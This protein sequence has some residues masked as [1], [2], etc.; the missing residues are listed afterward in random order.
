M[1]KLPARFAWLAWVAT[2]VVAPASATTAA[3]ALAATATAAAWAV[4]LWLGLIDGQGA[5]TQIGSVQR[6][7]RLIGFAGVGHFY[8]REASRA[9]GIPVGNEGDFFDCAVRLENVS[10]FG[11]G[12]TVGQIANV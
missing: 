7:D 5:S 3:K 8:E 4:G 11:F 10:Q 9:A 6:G 1:E 12:C 2:I